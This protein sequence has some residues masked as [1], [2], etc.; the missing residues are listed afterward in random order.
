MSFGFAITLRMLFQMSQSR[1]GSPK[2]IENGEYR[3]RRRR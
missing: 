3:R 2:I 1:N